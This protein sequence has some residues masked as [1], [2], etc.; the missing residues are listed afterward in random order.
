VQDQIKA[1]LA[2]LDELAREYPISDAGGRAGE[3]L[4][5]AILGNH[6]GRTEKRK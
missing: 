6:T 2:M 5:E 1:Q 3:N 4:W